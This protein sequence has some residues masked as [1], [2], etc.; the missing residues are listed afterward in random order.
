[1]LTVAAVNVRCG[2][3]DEFD[4]GESTMT[5]SAQVDTIVEWID[6]NLNRSRYVLMILPVMGIPR[7]LQR[8]LAQY[9]GEYSG[10]YGMRA[11][12][13]SNRRRATCATPTRRWRY[14]TPSMVFICSKPLR[15]FYPHVQPAASALIVKKAW[16]YAL[17]CLI[18]SETS[19][20]GQANNII[21]Q[22]AEQQ[23]P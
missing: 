1:M 4:R 18:S 3:A 8:L 20:A 6:D 9:K 22:R 21:F 19:A 2:A 15:A 17:K 14:F 16:P 12:N 10:R 5:I 7:H 23:K 11:R 13:G